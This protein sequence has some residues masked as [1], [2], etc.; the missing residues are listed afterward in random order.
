MDTTNMQSII[1]DNYR[2]LY[3]SKMDTIEEMDKFIERYSLSRLSQEERKYEQTNHKNWNWNSHLKTSNK[4]KFKTIWLPRWILSSTYR[5]VNI[6]PSETSKTCRRR[7]ISKFILWCCHHS[8]TK[9]RQRYHKRRKLKANV[10]D[11]HKILNKI[12]ANWIQQHI[13]IMIKLDLSQGC[14]DSSICAN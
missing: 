3:A 14:K 5:R 11:E 1:T 10:T 7:N 12:W 13:K 4:W 2:Q 6:Y 9:T 8:D